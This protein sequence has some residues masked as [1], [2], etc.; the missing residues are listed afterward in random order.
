MKRI[1]PTAWLLAQVACSDPAAV[2]DAAIAVDAMP[3]ADAGPVAPCTP[4]RGTQLRARLVTKIPGEGVV[5]ATS[6]P[7]DPRLFLVG[8]TGK[9]HIAKSEV[10]QPQPFIDLSQDNGGPVRGFGEMG[11]LG[12]AFHPNFASNHRFFVYYTGDGTNVVAAYTA[13]PAQ[14]DRALA[15]SGQVLLTIADPFGNHNGGMIE[16]GPDGFLYIGTGDGGSANDPGNRSQDRNSLLG[17][18][19]RLDV[20]APSN[21]NQYGIP[22]GNPFAA[23]G[24]APEIFML[25][26]RNPWR[27]SFDRSTGDMY[28]GDVGQGVWEELDIVP[29]GTG[30]GRDFGWKQ[31]EGNV[32]ANGPCDPSGKT[33]PN[34]VKQHN[35]GWCSIIGGAVYRGGCYPDLTGTYLFTDYCAGGLT[36]LEYQNGSVNNVR[37]VPGMFAAM[38][39]SLHADS[40]G[41]L[42]LTTTNGSVYQLEATP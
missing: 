1:L 38:P 37:S 26:L 6:P 19:L 17:K 15:G 21:G 11:L 35:E 2:P 27:W 8:Q 10:V 24:G 23:G 39:S 3:G 34:L 9:I 29:A 7:N 28:I 31:Y 30:A 14:P 18:M 40:R 12:L 36:A 25:G 13:D 4:T 33:F 32:C 41:E 20:D 42:Y 22:P 5:L 16:F